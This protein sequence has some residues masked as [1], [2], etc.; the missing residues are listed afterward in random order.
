MAITAQDVKTLREQTG[1]GMMDC[2]KALQEVN[3]DF[4]EALDF[5]KKQGLANAEKKGSRIAAEGLVFTKING[6]EAVLLE[7]NCETDFVAKNDDFLKL[8]DKL[9]DQVLAA[10][11]AN[12]DEVL[13]LDL[14]GESIQEKINSLIA[15][16]GEK[17]SLRRFE[18]VTST[19]GGNISIYNHQGGKIAVL[20]EISGDKITDEVGKNIGM[21]IAAMSP[22]YIDKSEVSTAD[23]EQEKAM[24][25]EQMKDSGKPAEI[26]EKIVVGKLDKFAGEMSLL[27]QPY[28]KDMG[29]KNKVQ[30]YLKEV[31]SAA[32]VIQFIRYEVGE[33]IEK[34]QDDFAEE[35]AK[36]AK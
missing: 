32:K 6:S 14:E 33:G 15:V 2:K 9:A 22:R 20:T 30:D 24:F 26:L 13:K 23:L 36:M 29:G 5:L 27:Q 11:P 35:V 12:V 28:V 21:Q 8:G 17:I 34:R 18:V 10:K 19:D 16:I 1:A 3:G 4:Q 31:D 25:L 7:L